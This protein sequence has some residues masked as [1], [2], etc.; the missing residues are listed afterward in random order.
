MSKRFDEIQT[1]VRGESAASCVSMPSSQRQ[2][3]RSG[4]ASHACLRLNHRRM[5]HQK[6]GSGDNMIRA[7]G[8][9]ALRDS[10]LELI[11]THDAAVG[12]DFSRLC[13]VIPRRAAEHFGMA[14]V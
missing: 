5:M 3:V 4:S 13:I 10:L 14:G 12:P 9:R 6:Y 8:R 7:T 2:S 1:G 11:L